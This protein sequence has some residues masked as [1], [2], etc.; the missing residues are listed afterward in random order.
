S[1]IPGVAAI[2]GA[3][4]ARRLRRAGIR[5]LPAV[6]A[7][8]I[9]SPAHHLGVRGEAVIVAEDRAHTGDGRKSPYPCQT[10]VAPCAK[11]VHRSR[12]CAPL[13]GGWPA[14]PVRRAGASGRCPSA[15]LLADLH[16]E[17]TVIA[18]HLELGLAAR[19]V[20]ELDLHR[21][22]RLVPRGHRPALAGRH[23]AHRPRVGRTGERDFAS[24]A[25]LEDAGGRIS[26]GELLRDLH[27]FG[28]A[29][30]LELPPR[31]TVGE[32]HGELVV[33]LVA[34]PMLPPVSPGDRAQRQTTV[35]VGELHRSR[36][37]DLPLT[38]PD[39]VDA[40]VRGRCRTRGCPLPRGA[41]VRISGFLGGE[42]GARRR[43]DRGGVLA[44]R[45]A[46]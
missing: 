12:I 41:G 30:D 46:A 23:L 38:V 27:S 21:T 44:G 10:P 31:G 11:P 25:H 37:A 20:T 29:L 43:G 42:N 1:R 5:L 13:D 32:V 40:P 26:E 22:R 2:K 19:V 14:Q 17:S 6:S 15:T 36:I 16:L 35:G 7:A 3:G 33:L 28:L 24:V 18:L 45:A 4:E 34:D 39:L 8:A 9:A